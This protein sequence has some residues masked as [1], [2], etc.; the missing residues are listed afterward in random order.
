MNSLRRQLAFGLAAGTLLLL[1]ALYLVAVSTIRD[2]AEEQTRTRLGH[3]AETLLTAL[4]L[5]GTA[6]RLDERGIH[7]IYRRPFSGHYYVVRV[8]DTELRSRSLW[9]ETL[10]VPATPL[11]HVTGPREQ[12]LLALT[13]RYNKGEQTVDVTV[14]E[15][16]TALET[17]IRDFQWRYGLVNLLLLIALLAVQQLALRHALRPLDATREELRRLQHGEVTTLSTRAPR[18]IVPLIAAINAALGSLQ[19][20]TERSQKAAGNL[21]HA[22]KGPLAVLGQLREHPDLAESPALR[23]TM[24]R[25]LER[26]DHAVQRELRRARTVGHAAPGQRVDLS[27]VVGELVATLEQLY[28]DRGLH[29][30]TGAWGPLQVAVD[31]HDLFELCGNLLDNACKWAARRVRITARSAPG[32]VHLSIEDDGPGVADAALA[33]LAKRGQRLDEH[34]PGHGLGLAIVADILADYDGQMEL[35]RAPELGGLRVSVSLPAPGG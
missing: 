29:F 19:R 35:D 18:E 16:L 30:E 15:E 4:D 33:D 23:T 31:G 7:P 14:A 27:D 1:L 28:G 22:L 11:T 6:P 32:R 20:R 34:V 9:D 21:A 25:E 10:S 24:D 17:A 12:P 26:L 8:A 3:D 5:D 13:T 2:L